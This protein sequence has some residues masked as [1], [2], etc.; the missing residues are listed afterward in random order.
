MDSSEK[1]KEQPPSRYGVRY[2]CAVHVCLLHRLIVKKYMKYFYCDDNN[3]YTTIK[4]YDLYHNN[5]NVNYPT[6]YNKFKKKKEED[7]RGDVL[8]HVICKLS[9][10]SIYLTFFFLLSLYS[11]VTISTTDKSA[12]MVLLFTSRFIVYLLSLIR[13]LSGARWFTSS[14][15]LPI[16]HS[17]LIYS[18]S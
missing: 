4:Y 2:M 12:Y 16:C 9:Q 8:L 1:K 11:S 10:R 7:R 17:R 18:S 6:F 3:V 13:L 5:C 15:P 14:R